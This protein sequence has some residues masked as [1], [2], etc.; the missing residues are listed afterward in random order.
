MRSSH[1]SVVKLA[2]LCLVLIACPYLLRA[3]SA[4]SLS[5]YVK[6]ASGAV[7]PAAK[8]NV[9]LVERGTTFTANTNAE[10]FYNFPALEPGTYTL[11]VEKQG[12][13]RFV[14]TGLILTV[15]QNL[16]AD[17]SLQVG[18]VTQQVTVSVQAPLVDTA[19][20][21]ISGL[22]DDR[23]IVD[24]P[25]NGRNVMSLSE[26]LP[27]VLNVNAPESLNDTR[28]GPTMNVNGGR[29]NMNMFTFDGAYFLNASRNTGMNYP[30]PDAVQ[31]FRMQTSNFDAAYG[32][33]AG[34]QV[35]VI[36]KSGTNSFHGDAWEF[37]RNEALNARNFFAPSVPADKENQFGGTAGGPIRKDKLFFF[38]AYQALIKRPESVPNEAFLLSPAERTGDFSALL[39]GTVLV[40]PTS[41]L[42]GAPLTTAAGA[43]CVVNNIIASGCISAVSQKLLQYI[44]VTASG[45]LFSLAPQPVN[46]YMYFGRIDANI[47]PKNVLFGHAYVDHNTFTDA[48]GGGNLTTFVH[49][50]SNAETDMVTLN[51]SYTLKPTLVNQAVVSFLRTSTVQSNY[52]TITNATLGLNMPQYSTPGS[53]GV[54]VGNVLEL[55]TNGTSITEYITQQL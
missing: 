17:A 54:N 7:I 38:G 11:A 22:V 40:D 34:S 46:D 30:P 48:T 32:H 3:Q 45:T 29:S 49:F 6:D 24:L 42:T 27:G 12:F 9:T 51:D 2:G 47:S 5:G 10:G 8:V 18:A 31:E 4:G 21:T 33:N 25:L 55:G 44:P 23:R 14:Q 13:R 53:I 16:R 1:L 50:R 19:S 39:P 35:A 52:P 41:P 26:I 15:R 28:S 37:L 43:P 20:G 36:S